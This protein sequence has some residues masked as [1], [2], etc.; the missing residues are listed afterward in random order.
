MG[1]S[2]TLKADTLK[3]SCDVPSRGLHELCGDGDGIVEAG[4]VAAPAKAGKSRDGGV[5]APRLAAL[6]T[7]ATGAPQFQVGC[8]ADR[9]GAA[10]TVIVPV[11]HP[12]RIPDNR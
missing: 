10:R 5:A 9:S 4:T 3:W 7:T 6:A 2:E 8:I 11:I 12:M 1:K